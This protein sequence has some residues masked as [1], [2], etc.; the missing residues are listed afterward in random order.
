MLGLSMSAGVWAKTYTKVTDAASLTDGSVVIL[1]CDTKSTYAGPM[2]SAAFLSSVS[3]KGDAIEITLNQ[4][5]GAWTLTTSEGT[6]YTSAAK[7]MNHT[8]N[9]E[10]TWTITFAEGNAVITSTNASYGW[11]QYNASSPRFLNYTS[12]QTAIQ[13]YLVGEGDE[14]PGGGDEPEN[15]EEPEDPT[16]DLVGD[17]SEANPYTVADVIALNNT[18]TGKFWVK[19][20]I[21]GTASSGTELNETD[22]NTNLALGT[23]DSFIPV[24]LPTGAVRN[25]LNVVDHPEL[26][27]CQVAVYGTL[28]K[29]FTVTGVKNV[30]D[31]QLLSMPGAYNITIGET[32]YAT[33]YESTY[34]IK[35]PLEVE[36]LVAYVEDGVFHVETG[37]EGGTTLPAN[38][39]VILKTA[40][41]GTYS[42]SYTINDTDETWTSIGMND[43]RGTDS[44]A[45]TTAEGDCYFYALQNGSKGVG[46][47][48]M[49]ETGAAFTN[50]AHKAYLALPKT[51]AVRTSYIFDDA[52]AISTLNAEE[53]EAAIFN[54]A[55]QRVQEAKGLVIMNGK[56][57]YIK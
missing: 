44:K 15:P 1:A 26:L 40:V 37:Y 3:A 21:C 45:T 20:M 28:E 8:G 2:G 25:G 12:N 29:Y 47:Y 27:G 9:G 14:E 31:Y 33:F 30:S 7:K 6:I 55:G 32:G 34:A 23:P 36:A 49:N 51:S 19:G 13:M 38:E 39:A 22:V 50:G 18:T 48:W 16:L 10:N 35:L 24:Q 53:G 4:A 56:K 43:L 17:G 52:T 57:S 54:L 42:L 11:I 46:F 41:P 5:E